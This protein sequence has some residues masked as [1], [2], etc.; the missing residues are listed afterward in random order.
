[1]N[2]RDRYL[3]STLGSFWAIAN[4]LFMLGLYTFVF[5][6]VFKVRLPGAD[7]TLAYVVWLISGYG[8]WM[9]T[10]EALMTSTSSVV[11]AAGIVKNMAFKTELLPISSA[12]LGLVTLTVSFSFLLIL[13]PFADNPPTVHVVLLPAIIA[14]HFLFVI[15]L[16]IWL[17]AI[18]VFVRDT[19]QV[20]P[21][22]LT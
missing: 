10:S 21:N 22:F 18:N 8:P 5:G 13:M 1:M 12:F 7:T 15:S 16:G 6:F 9:A 14:I 3:G 4:P 2:F 19:I 17:A 11:G 20:L